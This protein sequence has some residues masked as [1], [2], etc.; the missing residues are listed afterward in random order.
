MEGQEYIVRWRLVTVWTSTCGLSMLLSK[1]I[2]LTKTSV[3]L[4]YEQIIDSFIEQIFHL[5]WQRNSLH[6]SISKYVCY[7][8]TAC[9]LALVSL[10]GGTL[11]CALRHSAL[12][13]FIW[14]VNGKN[15][16]V[17]VVLKSTYG[18][19]GDI[20]YVCAV[21]CPVSASSVCCLCWQC[22][23]CLC[24]QCVLFVLAV[25]VVCAGSVCCLCWLLL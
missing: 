5:L 14:S 2:V 25:C 21:F 6:L 4:Q 16:L 22:V 12:Q 3:Y 9:A 17:V 11:A 20:P 8:R 13:H 24:W 7:S 10:G 19:S 1:V 23:C 18:Q 15:Q